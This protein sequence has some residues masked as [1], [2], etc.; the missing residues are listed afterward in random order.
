MHTYVINTSENKKFNS[1]LLFD[2]ANYNQIQWMWCSLPNIAECAEEIF[3]TEIIPIPSR[4]FRVVV[5]V[6]FFKYR[7]A[8]RTNTDAGMASDSPGEYVA[9]Y[10]NFIGQYLLAN[11]FDY[12]KKKGMPAREC[13]IYFVQYHNEPSSET[14]DMR[15][16]QTAHLFDVDPEANIS[17]TIKRP[18]AFR[19]DEEEENEE[20]P[21]GGKKAKKPAAEQ[22]LPT[23][24]EFKLRCTDAV[25]LPLPLPPGKNV[26]DKSATFEAFYHYYTHDRSKD[27]DNFPVKIHPPYVS[28]RETDNA[29][30]FDTLSLS[31]Y[32]I[33]L[34][35]RLD[36][37]SG[38]PKIL[39]PDPVKLKN[40]IMKAYQNV[41]QA[42]A[43]IQKSCMYY[44]LEVPDRGVDSK[45]KESEH[46]NDEITEEEIKNPKNREEVSK[47]V[48]TTEDVDEIYKDI[49]RFAEMDDSL[50]SE[51]NRKEM[52]KLMG[53]YLNARDEK[54][55]D[56]A[57][58]DLKRE[59]TLT[60]SYPSPLE[61]KLAKEEKNKK[62]Q[63]LLKLALD[64]DYISTD[65]SAKKAE[66]EKC[67]ENYHRLRA[68]MR[69][70]LLADIIFFVLSV[71]LL[72]GSYA[73]LQL[74]GAN[75]FAT[76]LAIGI[77]AVVFAALY[78][79][80]FALHILPL[81]SMLKAERLRMKRICTDCY[82][83]HRLSFKKLSKRYEN[84]LPLIEEVRYSL[85]VLDRLDRANKLKNVH[86]EAHQKM[87]E[88][89]EETL[90]GMHNSFGITVLSTG[91][92]LSDDD[93]CSI[94]VEMPYHHP[95]NKIYQILSIDSIAKM[96]P[97]EEAIN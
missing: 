65:Y 84:F 73:L 62:L 21:A 79:L 3:K 48:P 96:M 38:E 49:L 76:S 20:E 15:M 18:A 13:E 8:S 93:G 60:E 36:T 46:L 4:D 19:D 71:G 68:K 30:A 66:A 41:H 11:L 14:N 97:K 47:L 90:I 53:G 55:D 69:G 83:M 91:S 67:R 82:V 75:P 74:V 34:Y 26:G 22:T 42:R 81:A 17:K 10:K 58:V 54:R 56:S 72:V 63:K 37:V 92:A 43:S 28:L 77:S 35:E 87:L 50:Q 85:R 7:F 5:L 45:I 78:G 94:N 24:T 1:N 23:F 80:S 51:M 32:L 64:A 9:I 86:V 40:L 12:L 59:G 2:L 88:N 39:K 27:L 25:S 6:D 16:V 61:L 95:D 31:L 70:K 52:D 29:A 33:Y 44:K 89:V 57:S